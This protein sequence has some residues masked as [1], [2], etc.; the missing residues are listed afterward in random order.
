M[1]EETDWSQISC[2]DQQSYIKIEILRGKNPTKI[3]NALHEVCGDS[4]MDRSTVSRWATRFREGRVSIQ[5]DPRSGQPVTETDDTSVVIVSTLL[6]DDQRKSCEETAHEANMSTTSVFRI[7]TQTLQKRKVAAK[8]VPHQLSEEQKAARK[9]IA[10]ELLR[11]YEAEGE[12]FFNRIVATD[13]TWIQ[14]FEPQLKSQ[15]SQWEH[16]TSPRPKKCRRQESKVKLMMIM[17]YDKNGEIATDRVPPGSTVTAA[18][19]RK[20]LQDVLRLKIRQKRSATFT[21]GVLILHDN[22]QPHASGAVSEIL[23]K[24]GWQVLPHLPYSP[25]MSPPDFDLFP[26][27]KKPLHGKRFRGIEEVSNE[28]T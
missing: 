17:A 8:W 11:C 19:Y 5:D 28:V 1:E 9:R 2:S 6:E 15:S 20:F 12:Q 21:A 13:E 22:A 7:V 27:L 10:E 4:A 16:A 14:D 18:Y 26:K 24:Y 3:H 25:D 23:K